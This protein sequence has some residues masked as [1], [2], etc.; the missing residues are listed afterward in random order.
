MTRGAPTITTPPRAPASGR[1]QLT[2]RE[3]VGSPVA[4]PLLLLMS[5][6]AQRLPMWT[7]PA[8]LRH[9]PAPG[10]V[11]LW[12]AVCQ[13]H[14]V[15]MILKSHMVLDWPACRLSQSVALAWDP[16]H[17]CRNGGQQE[18]GTGQQAEAQPQPWVMVRSGPHVTLMGGPSARSLAVW[19]GT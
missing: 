12:T 19:K 17:R 8:M 16:N 5:C 1:S 13:W 18:T 3:R 4:F 10:C 6:L 15:A 14:A 9:L 2:S 7:C 11:C